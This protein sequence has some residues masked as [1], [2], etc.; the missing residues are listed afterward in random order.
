MSLSVPINFHLTPDDLLR[1]IGKHVCSIRQDDDRLYHIERMKIYL[2][3]GRGN[4]ADKF[5]WWRVHPLYREIFNLDDMRAGI[6]AQG[7]KAFRT[8]T[9][10]F[11]PNFRA[12][13]IIKL[14]TM[15]FYVSR[16]LADGRRKWRR[17][18]KGYYG[19]PDALRGRRGDRPHPNP[20]IY[21][22]VSTVPMS[23]FGDSVLKG[24]TL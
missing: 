16:H 1:L 24:L 18:K 14:D 22:S 23:F 4:G 5:S 7:T 6:Q 17:D 19:N 12:D 20:E 9:P 8:T 13:G 3:K 2:S 15:S 11:V 21:K 10:E